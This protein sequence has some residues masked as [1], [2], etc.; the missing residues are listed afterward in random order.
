MIPYEYIDKNTWVQIYCCIST[1]ETSNCQ[2]IACFSHLLSVK[3]S[4][5]SS[6]TKCTW[7]SYNNSKLSYVLLI[8]HINGP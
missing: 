8:S 5:H 7:V 4:C 1:D 3:N 6:N 2:N